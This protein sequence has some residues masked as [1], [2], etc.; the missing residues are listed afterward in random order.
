MATKKSFDCVEMKHK[1]AAKV[2]ARLAGMSRDEQLEYWRTRT[3]ELVELQ[4][5]VARE[6]KA[7]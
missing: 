5:R 1:G 3:E 2:Q 6:K 7:S 4:R